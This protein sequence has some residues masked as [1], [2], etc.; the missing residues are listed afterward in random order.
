MHRE[1]YIGSLFA[2]SQVLWMYGDYQGAAAAAREGY[3]TYQQTDGQTPQSAAAYAFRLA[4]PL[5]FV[6]ETSRALELL[7]APMPGDHRSVMS[8][9][10]EG[11]RL[12]WL[13]D[14]YREAGAYAPAEKTYDRAISYLGSHPLPHSAAPSMAYEGKALLL[15]RER[16]FAAAVPLYRLAIAGYA[17]SRYAADG[18]SIAAAKVELAASLA[19]L[20]RQAEARDLVLESGP[21]VELGLAPTHPARI[22]LGRLRR[23][24]S[25][26]GRIVARGASRTG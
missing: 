14:T 21:I 18:P 7:S 16:R 23:T 2:L 4:H 20:G 24:L 13:A 9:S 22:T 15:A 11:L 19:S 3:Q 25:A 17:N 26:P 12:L 1:K 8:N 6:G 5:A 10:F